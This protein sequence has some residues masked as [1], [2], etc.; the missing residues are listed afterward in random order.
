LLLSKPSF[1]AW[2]ITGSTTARE[3][4]TTFDL[5]DHAVFLLA[6]VHSIVTKTD[7]RAPPAAS[8]QCFKCLR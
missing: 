1:V 2:P 8:K 6:D 7:E 3:L 5:A 4:Q